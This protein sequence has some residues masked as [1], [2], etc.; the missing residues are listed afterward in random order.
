M[1][2]TLSTMLVE[3]NANARGLMAEHGLSFQSPHDPKPV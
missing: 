2:E 3:N 1:K